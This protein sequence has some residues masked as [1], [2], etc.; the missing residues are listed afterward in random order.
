[1][2]YTMTIAAL[3]AATNAYDGSPVWGLRSVNDHKTDSDIQKGY[4][5]HSTKQANGRPPYQSAA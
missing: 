3:L 4:G 2:K 5:D 1:M